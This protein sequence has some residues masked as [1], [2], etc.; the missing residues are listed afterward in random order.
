[1]EF[2]VNFS[3]C[4]GTIGLLKDLRGSLEITAISEE[5]GKCEGINKLTLRLMIFMFYR[6]LTPS[7]H[8]HTLTHTHSHTDEDSPPLYTVNSCAVSTP[9]PR[10]TKLPSNS[11]VAYEDMTAKSSPRMK[12]NPPRAAPLVSKYAVC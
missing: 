1:M 2:E 12:G 5:K 8:T 3:M 10:E 11:M 9:P 6:S 4:P 7:P